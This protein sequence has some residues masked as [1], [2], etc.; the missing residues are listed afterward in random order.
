MDEFTATP[1]RVGSCPSTKYV[2]PLSPDKYYVL[3]RMIIPKSLDRLRG[4]IHK[5]LSDLPEYEQNNIQ[6]FRERGRGGFIA[7]NEDINTYAPDYT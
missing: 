4:W 2:N 1:P 6:S 5:C 3:N 7:S